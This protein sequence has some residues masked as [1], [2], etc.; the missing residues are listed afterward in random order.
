MDS[1]P[2]GTVEEIF[3]KLKEYVQLIE[4]ELADDHRP[5]TYGIT[6]ALVN[7]EGAA[8]YAVMTIESGKF[9]E[10]DGY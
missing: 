10:N 3:K 6:Q 4:N 5:D 1:F 9:Q 8:A 7:I 2:F